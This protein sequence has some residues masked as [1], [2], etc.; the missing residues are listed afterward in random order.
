VACATLCVFLAR[1]AAA[2]PAPPTVPDVGSRPAIAGTFQF[3]AAQPDTTS[4]IPTG[5][6]PIASQPGPLGQRIMTDSAVVETLGQRLLQ[7]G[8]DLGEAQHTAET[9]HQAWTKAT[10][11]VTDLRQRADREAGEA[12]K[13][14]AALGPLAGYASDLHELS[15]L[16]PGLGQQPGGQ[17]TAHE[18]ERAEQAEQATAGAY[19]AASEK[20]AQMSQTRDSVKADFDKHSAALT[21]LRNQNS[22]AYQRELAAI[23]AQQ[24]AI[25]AGLNVGG[26]VNGMTAG[27]TALKAIAAA[28]SKLGRPYVWGAEGPDFFDCSGLVLWSYRQ[29]GYN[30]LPR[31]ANDQ[32]N[33]TRNSAVAVDKLLA[34]DLLFFATDRTDWRSI[35]HVALY[36]GNG[37]MIQAPST[38]DVV[39]IS[40]VWWS[41]FY[42]ATRVAGAVPA[43]PVPV[44]A[45]APA[46]GP[47]NP[48]S[49]PPTTPAPGTSPTE[50]PRSTPPS[51]S[52]S[53]TPAPSPTASASKSPNPPPTTPPAGNGTPSPE[54]SATPSARAS[55]QPSGSGTP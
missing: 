29:A 11:D 2:D 8:A 31:V 16:V 18:V 17:A 42:G 32:Y 51:A 5:A 33:A 41:E 4:G 47:G 43:V 14:A 22:I 1:P 9:A 52:P 23:D 20:A 25:G 3:P 53:P 10:N 39:R 36:Y 13:A 7:L 38:G 19:Q 30:Q 45:P 21:A 24:A 54:P 12:Y 46:P 26:A 6:P 50:P 28:K 44:P 35:H 48:T 27:S 40:P 49:K 37:Y 55:S 15:V 34:G